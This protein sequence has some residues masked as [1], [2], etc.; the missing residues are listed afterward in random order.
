MQHLHMENTEQIVELN[1]T[2]RASVG[3]WFLASHFLDSPSYDYDD[4][5]FS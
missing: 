4:G 5:S 2:R 3:L 1:F